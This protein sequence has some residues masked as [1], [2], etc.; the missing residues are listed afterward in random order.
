MWRRRWRSRSPRRRRKYK[1]WILLLAVILLVVQTMVVIERNL[2]P[3]LMH[4]AQMR[5]KQI[6]TKAINKAITERMA[7]TEGVDRLIDWRTDSGGK[8]KGFSLNYSAHMKVTAD[9]INTVQSVL[10]E[11]GEMPEHIP[12]G[13][14]FDSSVIASFG[15]RIP[16]RLSPV[17]SVEANLQ[18]RHH[19]A[20]INNLLVEVYI[21]IRAEVAIIIP[22]DSKPEVVETEVPISY[23]LVVGDVPAYFFDGKGN[24]SNGGN[25]AIPPSVSLPSLR[26][27]P[28]E[29][30]TGVSAQT[31]P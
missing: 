17:G 6:A 28:D 30:A 27:E 14:A 12:L 2:A 9:A 8:I 7:N 15:P 29:D 4:V 23:V 31:A 21:R 16:V 1:R 26:M 19:N 3:P 18:T 5:L 24:P 25:T 10:N 20:G 11:L 13:Q 22:F